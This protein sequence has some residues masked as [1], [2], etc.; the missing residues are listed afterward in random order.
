MQC[1]FVKIR[2]SFPADREVVEHRDEPE[3]EH[4]EQQHCGQ[5]VV[6]AAGLAIHAT[7]GGTACWGDLIF[8]LDAAEQ[9]VLAARVP[10]FSEGWRRRFPVERGRPTICAC[11]PAATAMKSSSTATCCCSSTPST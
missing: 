2:G 9:C 7:P 4:R 8:A 5:R 1:G 11:A 3:G 6:A 10:D